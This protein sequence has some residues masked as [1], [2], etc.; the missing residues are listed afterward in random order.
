M[1]GGS[2]E[3][4]GLYVLAVV[5]T[6]G[7]MLVLSALLG[8]RHEERTTSEPYE[9]G[10]L[11][12][13]PAR[14][15]FTA[16]FYLVAVLFVIFDLEVVFLVAWSLVVEQAGWT[17]FLEMAI[18]VAVLLA[19]LAYLWR[20]GALDWG[21]RRSGPFAGAGATRFDPPPRG[22]AGA[23]AAGAALGTS[24]AEGVR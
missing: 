14:L 4:L 12:S 23:D 10:V 17:G 13:G 2:W 21:P 9:G 1:S 3:A 7:G 11:P 19:A 24:M 8:E 22:R 15:R 18:F 16:R 5:A 20:L 6:V